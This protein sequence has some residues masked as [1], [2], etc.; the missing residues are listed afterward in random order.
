MPRVT[1]SALVPASPERVYEHVTGFPASG[2][3][4][5]SALE[6]RYGKLR[7]REHNRFTFLEDIGGGVTWQCAFDPPNQRIM[8]AV[9]STWSDRIDQFAPVPGGTRWTITWELKARGL[10]ACTKWLVFHLWDK[11]R[12]RRRIVL[13]VVRSFQETSAAG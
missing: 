6:A 12:V 9:D 3:A 13:P 8:R 2:P 4:N 5:A 10:P 7:E 1:V 11:Q